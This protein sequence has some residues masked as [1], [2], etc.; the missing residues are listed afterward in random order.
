MNN[1]QIHKVRSEDQLKI[2]K[3]LFTEYQKE[4]NVDLCFQSFEQELA[5]LPGIY[6]Q[7]DG[8]ILL[9]IDIETNRYVGCV[10]VK[11]LEGQDCEMKRLYVQPDFRK[12][13]YGLVL[14]QNII[15]VSKQLGYKNMYLDTLEVLSGAISLY[16]KIGFEKTN[17]YYDNP[18]EGVVYMKIS[19]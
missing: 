3:T 4:L 18:L 16:E 14:T 10:A 17:S 5:S 19:L 7:P 9:L 13:K 6:E 12:K 11:K 2:T 1:Y 15:E 8:E